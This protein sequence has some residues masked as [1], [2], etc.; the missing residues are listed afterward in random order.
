M[1]DITARYGLTAVWRTAVKL[2]VVWNH[3][4]V[5]VQLAL[6]VGLG[7]TILIWDASFQA[8]V[9]DCLGLFAILLLLCYGFILLALLPLDLQSRPK[10][11]ARGVTLCAKLALLLIILYPLLR[12]PIVVA[13]LLSGWAMDVK[14]RITIFDD[15]LVQQWVLSLFCG[16]LVFLY[17]ILSALKILIRWHR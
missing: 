4:L 12:W 9:E 16:S 15:F 17:F 8:S 14:K 10:Q 11:V 1:A 2:V 7:S 6:Y 3:F 5:S 13:I